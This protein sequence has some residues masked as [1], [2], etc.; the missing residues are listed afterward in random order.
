MRVSIIGRLNFDFDFFGGKIITALKRPPP[1]V[2]D[3]AMA[4]SLTRLPF[5]SARHGT[6]SDAIHMALLTARFC[7]W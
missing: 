4:F 6:V 5:I 1:S 3:D 2:L 7:A